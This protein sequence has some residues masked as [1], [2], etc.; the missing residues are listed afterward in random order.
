VITESATTTEETPDPNL[1]N[2]T[3]TVSLTVQ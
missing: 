1:A 3:A 2:N